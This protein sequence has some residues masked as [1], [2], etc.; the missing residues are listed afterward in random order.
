M[1]TAVVLILFVSQGL[2]S[3]LCKWNNQF[4]LYYGYH[5][6]YDLLIWKA[7]ISGTIALS[8]FP[9]KY[10]Q[11]STPELWNCVE[12]LI[13]IVYWQIRLPGYTKTNM[14]QYVHDAIHSYHG[15][16]LNLGITIWQTLL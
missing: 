8:Y 1:H 4:I 9:R 12:G 5:P 15:H 2:K 7:G 6:F 3:I 16:I 10:N 11:D 13:Y 14:T